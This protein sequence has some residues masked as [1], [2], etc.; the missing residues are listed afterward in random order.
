MAWEI[1]ITAEGWTLLRD[2]L[3]TWKRSSLM[4]AILDDRF[5]QV[6]Q[7]GGS[8]VHAARAALALYRRI[9]LAPQDAL[10]DRAFELLEEN[11]TCS[12]GGYEYWI[13]RE[14]YHT[15][16]LP[17]DDQVPPVEEESEE[18][19]RQTMARNLRARLTVE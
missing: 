15:V 17:E 2:I 19:F 7:R 3:H 4:Q 10:A 6:E 1:S 8:D 5:E 9:R 16:D 13:D 18:E 14:G 11:N 12:N